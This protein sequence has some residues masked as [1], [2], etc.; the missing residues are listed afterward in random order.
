MPEHVHIHSA[1]HLETLAAE[2]SRA[3]EASR[4]PPLTP[5]TVVVGAPALA[6]WLQWQLAGRLGI[7]AHID[8][9][10]PGG[11]LWSLAR[12]LLQ[13]LP[14]DDP[15]SRERLTWR[16][17]EALP[18]LA[19]RPG[20]ETVQ[21][22]L[23]RCRDSIGRFQLAGRLA[24]VYD[25]YLY[26]R[27]D[28][29]RTWDAGEHPKGPPAW[30][31]ELWRHVSR[32][33]AS[34][35]VIALD[36]LGQALADGQPAGL[37]GRVDFF[38]LHSLP[39]GFMPLLA[40]LSRH[41]ELH[42]WLLSPTEHYWADLRSLKARARTR[43][44]DPEAAELQETGHPLLASWG[45]EGQTFQDLLLDAFDSPLETSHLRPPERTTLL[46]H[47][48]ADIFELQG[49]EDTPKIR[50][51]SGADGSLQIH[52]AH[53]PLRECQVLHDTLLGLLNAD[54]SLEPEDI[55]VLVPKINSYAPYIEAV[56]GDDHPDRP[57]LPWHL[58]DV[59][60]ADAHP[61]LTAFLQLV[62]LP[63]SRF[64]RP[65][66]LA[67]LDIPQVAR[68]FGFDDDEIEAIH[69]WSDQARIFWGMDA[70]QKQDLDLPQT[71]ENT[72]RQGL[73]RL[74]LGY[75]LGRPSHYDGIAALPVSG[76]LADAV[77]KLADLLDRL[78][79]WREILQTPATGADWQRRLNQLLDAFFGEAARD[80]DG[81]LQRIREACAE[82]GELAGDRT[83]DWLLV[84][85]W[86][87]TC[88]ADTPRPGRLFRGGVTF[89]GML[90]LRGVPFRVIVLLGMNDGDF[91]RQAGR[92]EFDAL[93][94]HPRP[95]DP[96]PGHE[97]RF[98]LLE[99]L[100]AARERLIISYTGRDLRSNE[101]IPPSALVSELLDDL[102]R[103]YRIG[104]QKPRKVLVHEHPLQPFSPRNFKH[105]PSFDPWWCE[106][107][108]H[109]ARPAAPGEPEPW[110]P[111][112]PDDSARDVSLARLR[113]ILTHPLR[114]FIQ[115]RLGLRL[116]DPDAAPDTEIF[117]LE[118]LERYSL[119]DHLLQ[120]WLEGRTVTEA[121]L[122]AEGRLPH[123]APGTRVLRELQ[124]AIAS[125]TAEIDPEAPHHLPIAL[126]LQD[127]GGR[128][129][130]L[131]GRLTLRGERLLRLRPAAI[132][133]RDVVT[134][135]LEHLLWSL[136]EPGEGEA[137]HYGRSKAGIQRYR[138]EKKLPQTQARRHLAELLDIAWQAL[139]RPLPLPPKTAWAWITAEKDPETA[140][141]QAL[142][143]SWQY[144]GE[145]ER[146]AYVALALRGRSD[147]VYTDAD[148]QDW[149]LR[150]FK[151]PLEAGVLE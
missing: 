27:P 39:P 62:A 104:G 14:A 78:R 151:P 29:I 116:D 107:A 17:Y 133:G 58:A 118:G 139:H 19:P 115:R 1:N 31:G 69:D 56:F 125:L 71:H 10:L 143:G 40:A 73:E 84:R 109:L 45:R 37:P 6:L 22:Y 101:E 130:R 86:L 83:L 53:S 7:A 25:R 99:T 41:T 52:V 42:F 2:L 105:G 111:E 46:R 65:E 96:H 79:E 11:F 147:P 33:A 35:R 135:W 24:D 54:A 141:R 113:Q 150:L 74:L 92:A 3:L 127:S 77:G 91:P 142:E 95:G 114:A 26:Y 36:R 38:A 110:H 55:L 128:P 144:S 131:H 63:E 59:S 103:R 18:E 44:H 145:R 122:R 21:A 5:Q 106:I 8:Y 43:L 137:C 102:D 4:T 68:Q 126:E 34:H 90:P 67:L 76:S 72:W 100:L 60:I 149:A 132:D 64:T 50:H 80:P 61:L 82:L 89:C 98:L 75:A 112:P 119:E 146:D 124:E 81:Y 15:L 48:Q 23:E 9:P 30:Q 47:V 88:L 57:A 117:S 123:G 108:R 93:A 28:W 134:L 120:A 49:G 138:L 70:S 12:R 87:Q 20:F 85:H 94:G 97:D 148:F 140:A 13:D 51:L 136:T 16:L 121:D 129:W 66:V 32:D